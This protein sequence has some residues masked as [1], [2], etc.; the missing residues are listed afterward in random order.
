MA[1][2]HKFGGNWTDDK[3]ARVKKYIEAYT[4]IMNKQKFK[5]AYIDAFAGTGYREEKK[6]T[7]GANEQQSSIF[8]DD[9]LTEISQYS[10]GSVQIALKVDPGFD[11]YFFIDKSKKHYGELMKLKESFPDK[12]SK[13]ECVHDDAN[14]YLTKFCKKCD[15]KSRRALVFL[16]PYGMQIDWETIRAIA[17]TQ[18][19]DLWYLFPLGVGIN[20]LLKKE[21]DDIPKSWEDKLTSI[22]GTSEWRSAFYSEVSADTLFGTEVT[23]YKD[24]DFDKIKKFFIDRLKTEF[25]GVAKNP[26]LL[27]NSKKNPLYL[28][29][30]AAGN[31]KGAKTAVKIAEHILKRGN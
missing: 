14:Q 8:Q 30:F 10:E 20:R 5:V 28:L 18:A 19:I 9:E 24:A 4:K 2:E 23:T 29:C 12:S 15:W 22:L 26:L 17:G 25:P 27:Y 6:N 16:D 7:K 31:P 3:L 11:K 13:I 21:I 1:V